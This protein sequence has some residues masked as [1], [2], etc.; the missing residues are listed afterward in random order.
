MALPVGKVS[1]S[2]ITGNVENTLAM[3]NAHLELTLFK[4]EAP[5]EFQGLGSALSPQRRIDA[6]SELVKAY[7]S[8]VS[9]ISTSSTL[10]PRGS[11]KDGVFALHTGA[12]GTSI[13]A[14]ATSGTPAISVH[15]LACMLARTFLPSEATSIW[16][17]IVQTRREAILAD[18]QNGITGSLAASI[19]NI[20]RHDLTLWDASARAWLQTADDAKQF[21][22][23]QLTLILD[24]INLPVSLG[25]KTYDNVL[26]VW[27]TAMLALERL[28]TGQPQRVLNG[29]ALLA[30]TSWHLFPD[31]LVLQSKAVDVRFHDHLV[32]AS[33]RL[34]IGLENADPGKNEGIYWSLALS[35]FRFYGDPVAV[36]RPIGRDASR[37]SIPQLHLLAFGSLLANWGKFGSDEIGAARFFTTLWDCIQKSSHKRTI[38]GTAAN[39]FLLSESSWL[40]LL[41]SASNMLLSSEDIE[42]DNAIKITR[43]GR[44]R[45]STFLAEQQNWLPP[46]LGLSHASITDM[47]SDHKRYSVCQ[48]TPKLAILRMIATSLK[49]DPSEC[50]IRIRRPAYKNC[51]EYLTAVPVS[52]VHSKLIHRRWVE[53]N[54]NSALGLHEEGSLLT[55]EIYEFIPPGTFDEPPVSNADRGMRWKIDIS[56]PTEKGIRI[57]NFLIRIERRYEHTAPKNKFAADRDEASS[58]ED[59]FLETEQSAT[60]NVIAGDVHEIALFV[61]ANHGFRKRQA[62]LTQSLRNASA[63]SWLGFESMIKFLQSETVCPELV[64]D[65][66][67]SISTNPRIILPYFG[68]DIRIRT[69]DVRPCMKSLHALSVA[70]AVYKNLPGATVA[71]DIMT[72]PLHSAYWIPSEDHLFPH[73]NPLLRR[74]SVFSCIAMLESGLYN[75]PPDN[76][77]EVMA[78]SARNSLY[79]SKALLCDP[80]ETSHINDVTLILGNVGRNGMVLMIPPQAPRV[81]PMNLEQWEHI[82]HECFT[83]QTDDC[84]SSTSLHLSFTDYELPLSIGEHGSIDRDV[85]I[86]E[87][88]ISVYDRGRWVG[89]IDVLALYQLGNKLLRRFQ[90]NNT[91]S[92]VD[93]HPLGERMTSIASWEELLDIPENLG[94]GNVGV[95][96]AHNNWQARQ[97]AACISIQKGMQTV[98]L[99]PSTICWKCCYSVEWHWR[100]PSAT[101]G[102]TNP[103]TEGFGFE[104][105]Q[106]LE[107]DTRKL[108]SVKNL[109]ILEGGKGSDELDISDES[110]GSEGSNES[111][112]TTVPLEDF[113]E[114][115]QDLSDDSKYFEDT[116]SSSWDFDSIKSLG[117]QIMIY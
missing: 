104:E 92:H 98:I 37:I 81:R 38:S 43:L 78:I 18:V 15:L 4:I 24:N 27:T 5:L 49:L 7:G 63:N 46:L 8:R 56:H 39:K 90:A 70:T 65:Y 102:A 69:Y 66:L 22:Q 53:T 19:Q 2:A 30:L 48:K 74:E 9:E 117:T 44:R 87:T 97:A 109:K 73:S 23:K 40:Y 12:D 34:T 105:A 47:F 86:I 71:P 96:R 54:L 16:Y 42:H 113:S 115:G 52:G 88:V 75:F 26:N 68:K 55:G 25:T 17:E 60:F 62:Q 35:H 50:I 76:L 14:A 32:P 64:L 59:T 112:K 85:V 79:V 114:M 77:R 1:A 36:S 51:Y 20:D 83:N 94:R 108:L 103:G 58:I 31:L 57:R 67:V 6:E 93:S 111:R 99:P 61:K 116:S 106:D 100:A 33:G 29:A 13:W 28:L 45:G 80:F 101:P 41:T 89:D 3:V 21:Q 84:F 110:E 10:N 82:N 72:R 91:C 11:Q 95:V 107:D